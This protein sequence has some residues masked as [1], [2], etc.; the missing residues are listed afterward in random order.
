MSHEFHL[1]ES[2]RVEIVD[3]LWPYLRRRSVRTPPRNNFQE[4]AT[5][6][7]MIKI[8]LLPIQKRSQ[9]ANCSFQFKSMQIESV[10]IVPEKKGFLDFRILDFW[11]LRFLDFGFLDSLVSLELTKCFDGRP[12]YC[13]SNVRFFFVLFESRRCNNLQR[14]TV[15]PGSKVW[16]SFANPVSFLPIQLIQFELLDN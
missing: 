12:R 13:D 9:H 11:I 5:L 3:D 16:P 10:R 14:R 1:L 2:F 6:Q 7:R 8:S 15:W 4:H